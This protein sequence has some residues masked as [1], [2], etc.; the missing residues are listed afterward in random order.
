[1]TLPMVTATSVVPLFHHPDVR[2][3]MFE[4]DRNR[5]VVRKVVRFLTF[6][7]TFLI[8]GLVYIWLCSL[9]D[10]PGV[11][12]EDLQTFARRAPA[13]VDLFL[14]G[15]GASSRIF[16]IGPF[17]WYAIRSGGPCYIFDSRGK[18]IEWTAETG[19][20]GPVDRE[21]TIARHRS[22]TISVDQA[23]HRFQPN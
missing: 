12:G 19:E 22:T 4:S 6:L 20:G 13:P 15:E 17:P 23:I 14:A 10:V 21:L 18:L 7:A 1:M 9:G 8:A 16:W 3:S 2:L 5:Q 11:I